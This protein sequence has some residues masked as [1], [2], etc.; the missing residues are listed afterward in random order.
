MKFV[1]S[2]IWKQDPCTILKPDQILDKKNL[3]IKIIKYK[4]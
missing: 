1:I 4:N 3:D 2:I